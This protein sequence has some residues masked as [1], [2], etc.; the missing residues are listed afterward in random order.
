MRPINCN[1]PDRANQ[2]ERH[3]ILF[4]LLGNQSF[5]YQE[6]TT[7]KKKIDPPSWMLEQPS[8]HEGGYDAMS[9]C[10]HYKVGDC[11]GGFGGKCCELGG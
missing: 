11:D 7:C 10:D 9:L 6:K 1:I 3:R 2:S 5:L 4:F 8:I